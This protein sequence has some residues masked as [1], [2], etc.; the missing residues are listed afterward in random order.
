MIN[1]K[2]FISKSLKVI[3][4]LLSNLILFVKIEVRLVMIE[5]K[6]NSQKLYDTD[7][8]LMHLLFLFALLPIMPLFH[9]E[10]IN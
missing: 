3:N 1:S 4:N 2:I 8:N 5:L 9:N 10:S 6:L 7:Y